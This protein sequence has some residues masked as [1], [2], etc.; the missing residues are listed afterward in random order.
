MIG[1]ITDK[2][3]HYISLRH[4]HQQE[5]T[6]VATHANSTQLR[7]HVTLTATPHHAGKIRAQIPAN[8][9]FH[10]HFA[11]HGNKKPKVA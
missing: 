2:Q 5:A 3:G 6:K 4:Q 9:S 7:G 11:K 1:G 10:D 8:Q